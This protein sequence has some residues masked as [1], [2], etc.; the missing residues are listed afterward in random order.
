MKCP[1]RQQGYQPSVKDESREDD[2][3]KLKEIKASLYPEEVDYEKLE[4][5]N[6]NSDFQEVPFDPDCP[7]EMAYNRL[8]QSLSRVRKKIFDY[9][10]A[11][12]WELF[13]TLTADGEK[14]DRYD[15]M[16]YKKKL[17]KFL[18]N[19]QTRHNTKIK[20][21][22]I[23]EYHKDG[24]VHFHGLMTG[25]P[26]FHLYTNDKGFLGWKSYEKSFGYF[27][28]SKIRDLDAVSKYVTKYITKDMVKLP[29]GANMYISSRGL[30]EPDELYKG[31]DSPF[32]TP[33]KILKSFENDY[34][35]KFELS[36]DDFK[37][38][39]VKNES[40]E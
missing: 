18:N 28:C 30:N 32:K 37:E 21:L 29:K 31:Y 16:A 19:Y 11:N 34:C 13:V 27:S 3:K 4:K 8:P 7:W 22:L 39:C 35:L 14:L 25:I 5:D 15:I 17:G 40:G 10:S 9:A 33:P 1:V 2:C 20:Y 38:Y 36:E 12:N 6:L 23:P 26:E 24:A